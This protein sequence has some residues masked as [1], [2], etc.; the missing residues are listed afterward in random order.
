MRRTKIIATLGPASN[1]PEV[2]RELIQAGADAFRLN[3]SHGRHADHAR[4]VSTVRELSRESSRPIAIVADI[5]GP[6]IRLGEVYGTVTLKRDQPFDITTAEMIGNER[7][8]STPFADLPREVRPGHRILINDGLVEL[9]VTEIEGNTVRTRVVNGGTIGSKKGMNFPDTH[10]TIP[11]VTEKDREDIRFIATQDVDFV[12]ASFVR[13]RQDVEDVRELLHSAGGTQIGVIAKLEK[14]QAIA[15]LDEI[16]AASDGVMVARG[17]LGVEMLPEDVPIVQK[18]VLRRA[19]E[20]GRFA[21]TATQMLESMTS[22]ARPTRAEASDV[23]NAIFDGSDAVMLSGETASG[24]Y[25]TGAVSMMSR[26]AAMAEKSS[27]FNV[28][29]RRNPLDRNG[30]EEDDPSDALAGAAVYVSEHTRASAIVVFSQTGFTARLVSKFRPAVPIVAFTPHERVAR[31]M[32]LFW[33]V[34]P[35]VLPEAGQFH[36]EIVDRVKRFVGGTGLVQPGERIVL[37][38]AAPKSE[39]PRTNLLRID[40]VPEA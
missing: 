13:R 30:D 3:F 21:I 5:Q 28:L 19:A 8:V 23:A 17:D 32:N 37:L 27:S 31:Q 24:L 40:R 25:P 10:L 9:M 4:M 38:M 6:K 11:S 39:R 16:L 26:I 12:A 18:R 1:S 33:G 29:E 2:I 7:R 35:Y 34:R 14:P 15:A 20:M 22:N 36:E